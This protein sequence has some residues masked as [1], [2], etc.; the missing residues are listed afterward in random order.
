MKTQIFLLFTCAAILISLGGCADSGTNGISFVREGVDFGYITKVGV[1]PFENN[2]D[3]KYAAEKIRDNVAT[4]ILVLELF[5]VVDK[6]L[7]DSA[8]FEMGISA[9]TPMDVPLTKRLAQ[10]L[11]VQAFISGS[12]N[13]LSNN[14][15]SS[16]FKYSEASITIKLLD[17]ESSQVLWRGSDALNGYSLADRLFGLEPMD[18]FQITVSLIH[19]MLGTIP[20]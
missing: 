1:L 19:R 13:S 6:G 12:V 7:V 4:Q 2:T 9:N 5:D 17:S 16:S 8:M 10:R 3:E 14:R 15:G 20:K 11:G 18:I